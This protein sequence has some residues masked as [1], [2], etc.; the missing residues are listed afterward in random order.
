MI[1]SVSALI[2]SSSPFKAD[3]TKSR[4]FVFLVLV[5]FCTLLKT[6]YEFNIAGSK[7]RLGSAVPGYWEDIKDQVKN[8][9]AWNKTSEY[10]EYAYEWGYNKSH[11]VYE[12]VKNKT[13]SWFNTTSATQYGSEMATSFDDW[14]SQRIDKEKIYSLTKSAKKALWKEFIEESFEEDEE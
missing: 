14:L 13:N 4:N 12:D 3:S 7:I 6:H 11:S 5:S 9:S 10:G 8:T 1:K 2:A